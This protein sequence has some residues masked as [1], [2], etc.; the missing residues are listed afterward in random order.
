MRAISHA[1]EPRRVWWIG[2]AVLEGVGAGAIDAS[3][4][5]K[6]LFGKID[7]EIKRLVDAGE[8]AFQAAPPRELLKN[9][10]YYVAHASSESPRLAEVRQ[11]F[12]LQS[13]LPSE[14]ELEHAKGSISGHNRALLDTVSAAIKDDLLRVK[15]ALD[16]FLRAQ[17][18]DPAELMAQVDVLD[19]VGDTLGMLGLGVPRRVVVEQRGIDVRSEPGSD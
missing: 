10:L 19:R 4:A 17:G 5:V 1:V 6:L 3:P 15:E 13:L 11:A 8:A 18:N 2:S 14:K 12:K 16:I 7:R 9:L